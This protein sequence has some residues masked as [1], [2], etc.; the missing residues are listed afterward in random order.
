MRFTEFPAETPLSTTQPRGTDFALMQRGLSS[1]GV[2]VSEEP[3][4]GAGPENSTPRPKALRLRQTGSAR[5][6][7]QAEWN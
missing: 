2:D 3:V 6:G 4:Y 7:E 5:R 1:R